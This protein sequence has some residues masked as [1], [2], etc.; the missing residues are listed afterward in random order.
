MARNRD[1]A[2]FVCVRV[3]VYICIYT[4]ADPYLKLDKSIYLVNKS[5]RSK[6]I[7]NVM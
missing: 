6:H 1:K 7:L 4:I 2:H 3:C 5:G